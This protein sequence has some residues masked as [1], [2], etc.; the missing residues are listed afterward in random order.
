MVYL[1]TLLFGCIG[2]AIAFVLRVAWLLTGLYGARDSRLMIGLPLLRDP[3]F[4]VLSLVCV[5]VGVYLA[6]P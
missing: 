3:A 5:G 2:L 6:V 1:K 4:I